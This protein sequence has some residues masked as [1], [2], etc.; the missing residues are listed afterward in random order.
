MYE[1]QEFQ[2][3]IKGVFGVIDRV[4]GEIERAYE[5]ELE[6]EKVWIEEGGDLYGSMVHSLASESHTLAVLDH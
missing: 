6:D 5:V 3:N 4:E 2:L 1:K